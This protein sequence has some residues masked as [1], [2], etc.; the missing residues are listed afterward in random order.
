M[1]NMLM[2]NDRKLEA[3]K[4]EIEEHKK[5]N[6]NNDYENNSDFQISECIFTRSI[7]FL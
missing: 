2:K 1:M 5:A 4:T 6:A 7:L 3:L